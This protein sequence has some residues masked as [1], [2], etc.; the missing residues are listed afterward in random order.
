MKP[1][2]LI[3]SKTRNDSA[4]PRPLG[5]VEDFLQASGLDRSRSSAETIV[6]SV[7]D[8]QTLCGTVSDS[9]SYKIVAESP[10]M[11]EVLRQTKI[12][13][14]SP[15]TILLEGESGT[16]KELVAR[17]IHDAS[18]RANRPYLR[19][20][21][22]ALSESLVESEL[23]G[24]ERGAF[25]GAV[26]TRRGAFESADTGTLLLDEISEIPVRIQAKLLRILEESEFQRVGG[27]RTHS[28]D[29]R[30]I[31]TTNR[32]L[33]QEVESGTFRQDLFYRLNIL[34]IKLPPLRERREDIVALARYFV[35]CF[36]KMGPTPVEEITD[37]GLEAL[38]AFHWPGNVRQLRNVM[39]RACLL[40][41]SGR[42]AQH[43]LREL[44]EQPA[45]NVPETFLQLPL[46]E[47]ERRVILSALSRYEGNKTE[48]AKHL[49]V[50]AR[51]LFN[52]LKRYRELGHVCD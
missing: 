23:F 31:A 43:D 22:A 36:G 3:A 14:Q 20:N 52:K 32:R 1:I 16:G 24:H 39:Y 6:D 41:S 21:C 47:V 11:L 44:L 49:G 33:E 40:N 26:E 19:T 8:L 34:R 30:V 42:I 5:G 18:V 9:P 17:M 27:N 10:A 4:V 12:Y 50:T 2:S 48:A 45:A 37:D 25:T 35:D 15:A 29:V 28:L 51:T 38:T 7:Q 13:A 46:E